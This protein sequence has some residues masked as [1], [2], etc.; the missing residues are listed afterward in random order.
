MIPDH[1]AMQPILSLLF[2]YNTFFVYRNF[3]FLSIY[4]F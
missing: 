3:G 4:R 2:F 1:D